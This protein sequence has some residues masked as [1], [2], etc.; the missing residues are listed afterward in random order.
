MFDSLTLISNLQRLS[1]VSIE[2]TILGSI[3]PSS[4]I[5][6]LLSQVTFMSN[7]M[8]PVVLLC[9]STAESRNGIGPRSSLVNRRFANGPGSVEAKI[10]STISLIILQPATLMLGHSCSTISL[11][12]P[13]RTCQLRLIEFGVF[14]CHVGCI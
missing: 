2:L 5:S 7:L 6:L 10:G 4:S 8:P 14:C 13:E 1:R 3:F 11:R 12:N 9:T